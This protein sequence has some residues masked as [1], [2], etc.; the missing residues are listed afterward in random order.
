MFELKL[1]NR[2]NIAPTDTV[3]IQALITKR[4]FIVMELGLQIDVSDPQSTTIF[5]AD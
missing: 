1:R 5:Q 3:I 4:D 2:Q